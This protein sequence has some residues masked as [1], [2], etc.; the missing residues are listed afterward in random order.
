MNQQHTIRIFFNKT[1]DLNLGDRWNNL[2][3][4][5]TALS[6]SPDLEHTHNPFGTTLNGKICDGDVECKH[7]PPNKLIIPHTE[8]VILMCCRTFVSRL[9]GR[10]ES[11]PLSAAVTK[12][13]ADG[14]K[15]ASDLSGR[16]PKNVG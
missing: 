5:L 12:P 9:I 2:Q 8:W 11:R 10:S 6:I 14:A 13:V 15:P 3:L 7:R 4:N 1:A 16:A